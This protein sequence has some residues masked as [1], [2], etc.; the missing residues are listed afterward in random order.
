MTQTNVRELFGLSDKEDIFCDFSCKEGLAKTGRL[1][2][3]TNYTCFFSSVMGFTS[4]IVIP[5]FEIIKVVKHSSSGIKLIAEKKEP[6]G[7]TGGEKS[8]IYTAFQSR[9]TS[10]KYIY[11]LWCNSSPYADSNKNSDEEL[12]E[13][14]DQETNG[15]EMLEELKTPERIEDDDRIENEGKA[16]TGK[17]G[18]N[19]MN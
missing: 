19:K 17:E 18:I 9:D 5:W 11:R 16:N 15:E 2:L 14:C 13:E 3:T 12:V 4:K 6:N 7:T 1:Y 8:V 10:F